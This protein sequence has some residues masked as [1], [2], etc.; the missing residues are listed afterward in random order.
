MTTAETPW[1]LLAA[2]CKAD[3][4]SWFPTHGAHDHR[5]TT[6]QAKHLC[7]TACE[8]RRRCGQEAADRKEVFGVWAG[9]AISDANQRRKLR[10]WLDDGTDTDAEY[11]AVPD[12]L[13]LGACVGG[14]ERVLVPRDYTA[15]LP[16][17]HARAGWMG[18]C[19]GCHDRYKRT[20]TEVA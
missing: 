12:E 7:R 11:P 13:R 3:P 14:C 10:Q 2:P 17:D 16:P 1:V 4:D 20:H 8:H 5:Y 9:F 15:A 6:A 19:T 18:M